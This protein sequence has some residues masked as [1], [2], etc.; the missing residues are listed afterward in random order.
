MSAA[1]ASEGSEASIDGARRG[2][3]EAL[4]SLYRTHG[5]VL[6]RLAYRLTGTRQDAEDV[7]HDVF[8]GLPE[9]LRRYAERGSFASLLERVTARGALMAL[10]ARRRRRG[11]ARETTT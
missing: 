9:A 10:R 2:D 7:G 3:P 1:A 11:A 8:V 4:A 6:Y 5:A